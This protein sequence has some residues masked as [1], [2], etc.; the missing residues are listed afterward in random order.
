MFG[1]KRTRVSIGWDDQTFKTVDDDL[2]KQLDKCL[3]TIVLASAGEFSVVR[4]AGVMMPQQSVIRIVN[5]YPAT[6]AIFGKQIVDSELLVTYEDLRKIR[7]IVEKSEG[8]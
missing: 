5:R 4:T 1:L 8:R 6:G 7:K 3:K 2:L